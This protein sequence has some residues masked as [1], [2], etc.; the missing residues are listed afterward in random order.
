ME[1]KLAHVSLDVIVPQ[2]PGTYW[3]IQKWM[4][5]EELLVLLVVGASWLILKMED[6]PSSLSPFILH[7]ISLALLVFLGYLV[8]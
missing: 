8:D 3:I 6:L 7:S 4:R 1:M 5:E 2:W